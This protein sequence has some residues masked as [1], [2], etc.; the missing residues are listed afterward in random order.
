MPYACSAAASR[1]LPAV[2]GR[3][4]GAA[5]A[6]A[7]EGSSPARASG[8]PLVS[9]VRSA[10]NTGVRCGCAKPIAPKSRSRSPTV[11]LTLV[12]FSVAASV[13][14][15][16]ASRRGRRGRQPHAE[17]LLGAPLLEPSCLGE[18][19]L[20]GEAHRTVVG[21]LSAEHHRLAGQRGGEPA[22]RRRA[23]LGG[24]PPSP[25][26][27]QEHIAELGLPGIRTDVP[28]TLRVAPIEGDCAD[29]RSV[30]IDH[31]KAR[32]PPGHFRHGA[33]ELITRSRTTEVGAHLRRCEQLDERRTVSRLGL[34]KDEPFGP[35]RGRWP[36]DG[37]ESG[38]GRQPIARLRE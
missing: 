8:S 7:R 22:E 16:S 31:E 3:C 27:W 6:S 15:T 20:R 2:S 29:H 4:G 5:V 32:A 13:T 14:R 12:G 33:F 9:A 36:G 28:R 19:Q 1:R 35:Y 10:A 34:A 17:P 37:S 26:L 24:I 25:R 21:S 18:P 38:H 23:R 30:E 11:T